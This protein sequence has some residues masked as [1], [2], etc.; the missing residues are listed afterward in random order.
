MIENSRTTNLAVYIGSNLI[1]WI[2]QKQP[3]V[4]QSSTEAAEY[5]D[6]VALLKELD[7]SLAQPPNLWCDNLGATYLCANPI[8]HAITKHVDINYHFAQ[9]KVANNELQ[10]TGISLKDQFVDI[11]TKALPVAKFF[12]L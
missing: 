8:F 7:V 4:I 5:D 11:L 10:P 6:L 1:S 12:D 2:F 9:D 3:T